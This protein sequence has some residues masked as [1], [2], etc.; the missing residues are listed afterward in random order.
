MGF[1]GVVVSLTS[2]VWLVL[3]PAN[4]VKVSWINRGSPLAKYIVVPPA[5]ECQSACNIARMWACLF[6]GLQASIALALLTRSLAPKAAAVAKTYVGTALLVAYSQDVVREVVAVGG[7]V[8]LCTALILVTA[9]KTYV[10][11]SSLGVMSVFRFARSV[12]KRY[13]F[14]YIAVHWLTVAA[15]VFGF[16]VA[17]GRGVNIVEYI[18]R[19]PVVGNFIADKLSALDVTSGGARLG[20]AWACATATA[21]VRMI[22]DF[23]LT[24]VL[25]EA[26]I[27]MRSP[28]K[29]K[30]KK[31]TKAN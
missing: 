14:V 27:R 4:I 1:R 11:A 13:G 20:V 10:G 23:I 5:E 22:S 9:P 12:T 15:T 6:W 29:T 26:I 2:C 16:W 17:L 7:A 25:G 28:K 19:I 30:G 3:G 18:V 21:P 31:T 24:V 8:E